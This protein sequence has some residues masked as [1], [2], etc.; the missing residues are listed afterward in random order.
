MWV[1]GPLD[2]MEPIPI[3][4]F[5]GTLKLGVRQAHGRLSHSD[6]DRRYGRLCTIRLMDRF[7]EIER[8]VVDRHH[9]GFDVWRYPASAIAWAVLRLIGQFPRDMRDHRW[10]AVSSVD[11]QRE[12]GNLRRGAAQAVR[13]ARM[14]AAPERVWLEE[15]AGVLDAA[16]PLLLWAMDYSRLAAN[17]VNASRG[18]LEPSVN[19]ERREVTFEYRQASD[20]GA[21][22]SAMSDSDAILECSAQSMPV[23][24][25][26]GMVAS[27]QLR[28]DLSLGK[29][30]PASHPSFAAAEVW[31]GDVISPEVAGDTPVGCGTLADLRKLWSC[32]WTICAA[33]VL[34]EELIDRQT[35][36]VNEHPSAVLAM[37]RGEWAQ[38][39]TCWTQLDPLPL[40][41]LIGLMTFDPA[42]FHSS[43]T[44]RPFVAAGEWLL[45][46]PRVVYHA[47]CRCLASWLLNT[48]SSHR[49]FYDAVCTATE[50]YWL[51]RMR[52]AF[53]GA[54]W[55]CVREAR[56]EA[57]DWRI[58]PDILAMDREGVVLV[59]DFKNDTVP[60]EPRQVADR[61]RSFDHHADQLS[62][63]L[64]FVVDHPRLVAAKFG[65]SSLGPVRT[66]VIYRWPM[67]IPHE[68][69]QHLSVLHVSRVLGQL[70]S[71]V[72]TVAQLLDCGQAGTLGRLGQAQIG[73]GGWTFHV[74]VIHGSGPKV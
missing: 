66:A 45:L 74:P 62:R 53:V 57:G 69:I 64:K 27:A 4:V 23:P 70:T 48:S 56:L 8:D 26:R 16:M 73:V 15:Q 11:T 33:F 24:Q 42:N 30:P 46:C 5:H 63:Y 31:A 10:S 25:I 65:V 59:A 6:W 36:F 61:L 2:D 21:F 32:L 1:T 17:F 71:G 13:W 49:R 54:G 68:A 55:R 34:S 35:R 51:E 52:V 44:T 43:M 19:E 22:V 50:T 72:S 20:A 47:D 3:P 67:A 9:L 58:T 38:R 14:H 39:L 7:R 12:W 29:W 18:A 40:D 41:E 28:A 37:T 60:I